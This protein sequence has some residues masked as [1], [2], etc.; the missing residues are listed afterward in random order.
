MAGVDYL[1]DPCCQW[2]IYGSAWTL[3][4]PIATECAAG[5]VVSTVNGCYECKVS[6]ISNGRCVQATSKY[7][8][9]V[10]A[11]CENGWSGDQCDVLEITCSFGLDGSPLDATADSGLETRSN[12][13]DTGDL[14]VTLIASS[15]TISV[16]SCA[17]A[18][19]AH[20]RQWDLEGCCYTLQGSSKVCHFHPGT[21]GME[22]NSG[23]L[24]YASQCSRSPTSAPTYAPSGAPS[25]TTNLFASNSHM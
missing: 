11:V 16:E 9:C 22:S 20:A 8:A 23:N 15:E 12:C 6:D 25:Y 24:R 21:L 7:G 19:T 1:Y 3:I 4:Q 5:A 2:Y 13:V 18:C 10:C 17:A 14:R